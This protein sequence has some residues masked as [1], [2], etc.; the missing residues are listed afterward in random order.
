MIEIIEMEIIEIFTFMND[1]FNTDCPRL[2]GAVKNSVLYVIF[3]KNWKKMKVTIKH[4]N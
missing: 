1:I 2:D 3:Y 4:H